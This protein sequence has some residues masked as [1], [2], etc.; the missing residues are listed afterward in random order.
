[1]RN[2]NLRDLLN[3][4][5]SRRGW[6]NIKKI[7]WALRKDIVKRQ[8]DILRKHCDVKPEPVIINPITGYNGLFYFDIQ[9]GPDNSQ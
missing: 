6:V 9:Y 4:P 8:S 1:M 5:L 3:K 7:S 2:E